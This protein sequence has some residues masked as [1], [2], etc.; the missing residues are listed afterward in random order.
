MAHFSI[1]A[2]AREETRP[3]ALGQRAIV[4]IVMAVLLAAG[5]TAQQKPAADN[6]DSYNEDRIARLQDSLATGQDWDISVPLVPARPYDNSSSGSA[7]TESIRTGRALA[8][9]MYLA[10]DRE[11]RQVQ[12][13][14]QARPADEAAQSQLAEL[15][16]ALI[17]R[18]E[19]N[20]R[21]EYLYAAAV[22]I[23][24]L[25]QAEAPEPTVQEFSQQLAARRSVLRESG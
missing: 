14:L 9:E 5:A 24:L 22:Y 3:G 6:G 10:L 2:A 25:R 21:F 11:L 23:E 18:I 7:F 19:I 20:I 8:S 13:R 12:R 15:R 16:T 17:E 4:A 1:R